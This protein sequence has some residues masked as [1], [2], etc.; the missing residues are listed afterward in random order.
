MFIKTLSNYFDDLIQNKF[1]MNYT[2]LLTKDPKDINTTSTTRPKPGDIQLQ[3]VYKD[4][5]G[6]IARII[7]KYTEDGV[8]C[9]M[10][11]NDEPVPDLP[12][13]VKEAMITEY[14]D[15][16]KYTDVASNND[17]LQLLIK[18]SDNFPVDIDFAKDGDLELR[19]MLPGVVEERV[20][21][22]YNQ[23]YLH[24]TVFE[25]QPNN[26]KF[27]LVSNLPDFSKTLEKAVY[28]DTDKFNIMELK[29]EIIQGLWIVTV[30]VQK[31]EKPS[32]ITFKTRNTTDLETE[33][34]KEQ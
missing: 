24:I 29:Y 19:F 28:I 22:Q 31:M 20:E 16:K 6:T 27:S 33:K 10:Y 32:A 4:P 12:K 1:G 2:K 3:K 5:N 13:D 18:G 17:I 23:Q 8:E 25:E 7:W 26:D 14:I 11:V 15:P 34:E 21:L 9:T 30:P